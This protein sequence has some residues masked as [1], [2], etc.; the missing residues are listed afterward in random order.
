MSSFF[1]ECVDLWLSSYRCS[2]CR[3]DV[4]AVVVSLLLL[5]CCLS[6]FSVAPWCAASDTTNVSIPDGM[7]TTVRLVR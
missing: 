1:G 7:V 3:V 2:C 5:L 4:F 6:Y